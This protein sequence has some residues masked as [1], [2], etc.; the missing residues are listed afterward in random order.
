MVMEVVLK[1]KFVNLM[2]GLI[3]WYQDKPSLEEN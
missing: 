1:I 3:V 2:I